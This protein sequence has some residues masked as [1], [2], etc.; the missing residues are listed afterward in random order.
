LRGDAAE[1]GDAL[2]RRANQLLE[3]VAQRQG[4]ARPPLSR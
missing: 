1:S 3:S 2:L 4:N